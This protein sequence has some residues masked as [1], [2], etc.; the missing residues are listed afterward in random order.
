MQR[1][2]YIL[3]VSYPEDEVVSE[4]VPPDAATIAQ[5]EAAIISPAIVPQID[6]TRKPIGQQKPESPIIE[7]QELPTKPVKNPFIFLSSTFTELILL[8]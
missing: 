2:L 5:P 7:Q 8:L 3:E 1:F 4:E 6:R